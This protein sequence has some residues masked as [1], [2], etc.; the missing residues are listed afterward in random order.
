MQLVTTIRADI[1]AA[2]KILREEA[3]AQKASLTEQKERE[4]EDVRR[5]MR[6]EMEVALAAKE[7]DKEVIRSY[8]V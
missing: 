3:E 6:G 8:A 4:K 5:E 2:Q 7:K 1:E